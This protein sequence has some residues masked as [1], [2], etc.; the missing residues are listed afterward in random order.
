M[1][2]LDSNFERI[3]DLQNFVKRF[4]DLDAFELWAED[5]RIKDVQQLMLRCQEEGL[6]DHYIVLNGLIKDLI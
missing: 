1:I 2:P 6:F 3:W 4:P 5:G